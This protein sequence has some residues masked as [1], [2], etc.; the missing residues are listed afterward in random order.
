M[1]SSLVSPPSLAGLSLSSQ[2]FGSGR[3]GGGGGD[4]EALGTSE[5]PLPLVGTHVRC[6][7]LLGVP[8]GGPEPSPPSLAGL[9]LSSQFSG[10]S[11]GG[12]RGLHSSTSQ[13]NLSRF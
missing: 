13:L 2:I 3:D 11:G 10:G 4:A 8:G 12:G 7:G 6:E 1:S 9:S 5:L